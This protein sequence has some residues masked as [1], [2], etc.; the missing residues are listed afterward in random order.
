MKKVR[1]MSN[2]QQRIIAGA[3]GALVLGLCIYLDPLSAALLL[4]AIAILTQWE[5]YGLLGMDGNYPFRLI[6]TFIGAASVMITYLVMEN[7][8]PLG[9]FLL[10]FP[11]FS[12]LFILK[13]YHHAHKPFIDVALTVTG[14]VYIA[15]SFALLLM[16]SYQATGRYSPGS[17]LGFLLLLWASD[18]GAY[19]AGKAFGK[20][21]LFER[22]SPKKTWEGLAGGALLSIS[23]AL[24]LP[25][26][27]GVWS[28]SQWM[29]MSVIIVVFGSYGDLVESQF[30]R[31]LKIKDSGSLIPGH[32][33]FMD[34]F[35]GL[36][37]AAPFIA[38]YCYFISNF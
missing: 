1:E 35:D 34:R 21:K 2:L 23:V 18:V 37:L 32:G 22:V 36:L 17:L 25:Q 11:L 30:K 38:V 5:F 24:L 3:L 14:V 33:G 7:D 10:L 19:F 31:S 20:R 6:G 12:L 26:L 9:V 16:S 8:L 27:L 15:F 29:T 28:W 4:T 13:L